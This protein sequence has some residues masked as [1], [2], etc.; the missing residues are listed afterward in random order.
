MSASKPA[1]QF[2]LLYG[3]DQ[4]LVR[5]RAKVLAQKW[6]KDIKDPFSVCEFSSAQVKSD[7]AC[8][9]DAATALSLT[10][11]DRVLRVRDASDALTEAVK[12]IE[13][14]SSKSW[15][16][17]IEAGEL[18]PRSS[19]RKFFETSKSAAAIACYADEGRGLER[20]IAETLSNEGVR[21]DAEA[22]AVL[23]TVLGGDRMIIRMELEKLALYIKGKDISS[24]VA[25]AEDVLAAIGDSA[26]APLDNLVYAV[27]SGNQSAIDAALVKAFSEGLNPVVIVRAVQRHFHSLHLVKGLVEQGTAID[28]AVSG[29]RPPVF[30]KWKDTFNR[31]ARSWSL[32]YINRALDLAT[33]CEEHCKTTG[34][35]AEV[36]CNRALMRIAQGARGR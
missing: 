29:L 2:I 27:G 34:M 23:S 17:V 3:P 32:D 18:S 31:Q 24:S 1:K 16:V 22:L 8:L 30:Y 7:P 6:V 15:P 9:S 19:L 35:P 4:G 12:A 13:A 5:E 33:E 36:L 20:V 25:T 14:N 11:D 10:G 28:A 21:A 26:E